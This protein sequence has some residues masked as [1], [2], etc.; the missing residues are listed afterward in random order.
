M[1]LGVLAGFFGGWLDDAITWLYTTKAAIPWLLLV[2]AVDYVFEQYRQAAANAATASNIPWIL[3]GVILALGLTDW[4][5]L[6][7]LMGGGYFSLR[8]GYFVA[9]ARVIHGDPSG[10][11]TKSTEGRFK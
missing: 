9:A 7:R 3:I 6:C 4:V 11:T 1:L 5:G 2:I 10:P 8:D